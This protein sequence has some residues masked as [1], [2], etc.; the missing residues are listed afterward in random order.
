METTSVFV[1]SI[2]T[3]ILPLSELVAVCCTSHP[4]C[5]LHLVISSRWFDGGARHPL[6]QMESYCIH[7]SFGEERV[8]KEGWLRERRR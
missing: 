6:L 7:G 4:S 1:P 2:F 3:F 8:R 5:V